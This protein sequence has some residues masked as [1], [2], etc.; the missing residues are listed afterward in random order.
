MKKFKGLT[1]K[2]NFYEIYL[3][4]LENEDNFKSLFKEFDFNIQLESL[5][6]K[7][8]VEFYFLCK[9]LVRLVE[10]NNPFLISFD[11]DNIRESLS[12]IKEV[13]YKKRCRYE[14]HIYD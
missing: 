8:L 13:L 6:N 4:T 1:I 12:N 11:I 9:I 3:S 5:T 7:Q 14:M 2:N 10:F